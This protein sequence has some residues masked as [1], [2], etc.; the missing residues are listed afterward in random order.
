MTDLF[1]QNP[2]EIAARPAT[3]ARVRSHSC[4]KCGHKVAPFGWAVNL[5]KGED[6][7]WFCASCLPDDYYTR[8]AKLF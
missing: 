7:E 5:R 3:K 1:N 6:G 2:K 8:Q 4:S